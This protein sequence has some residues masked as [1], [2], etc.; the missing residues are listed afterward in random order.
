VVHHNRA[1]D[2]GRFE[3]VLE[4]VPTALRSVLDGQRGFAVYLY[5][6]API[7]ANQLINQ[8]RADSPG[9]ACL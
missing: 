8:I 4:L 7:E 6:K 5:G 2:S 1:D 3:A 9:L